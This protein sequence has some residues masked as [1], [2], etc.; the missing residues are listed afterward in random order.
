[1]VTTI[2]LLAT[3]MASGATSKAGE[4]PSVDPG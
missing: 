1:L 2:Q 4:A 3:A